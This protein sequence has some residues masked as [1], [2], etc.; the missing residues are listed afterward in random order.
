MINDDIVSFPFTPDSLTHVL[1]TTTTSSTID[2]AVCQQIFFPVLG[3]SYFCLW[4]EKQKKLCHP[5]QTRLV[6][7][8]RASL[9]EMLVWLSSHNRKHLKP[10]EQMLG[11]NWREAR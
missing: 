6:K 10:A 1:L 4:K 11:V 7:E 3:L 5:P 2:C 9:V 8:S